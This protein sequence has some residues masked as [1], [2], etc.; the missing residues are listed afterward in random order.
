MLLTIMPMRGI[1]IIEGGDAMGRQVETIKGDGFKAEIHETGN[2]HRALGGLVGGDQ[3]AG[4][5][6]LDNGTTVRVSGDT[7]GEVRSEL[8]SSVRNSK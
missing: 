7:V 4:S 2:A 8:L 6:K 5:A 3:Y 1:Y